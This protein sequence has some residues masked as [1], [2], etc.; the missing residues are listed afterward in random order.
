MMTR[1]IGAPGGSDEWVGARRAAAPVAVALALLTAACT[2]QA[3]RPVAKSMPATT[4]P[5]SEAPG[6]SS[7]VRPP[8]ATGAKRAKP[9]VDSCR[10]ARNIATAFP[11][12]GDLIIG[13]LSYGGLRLGQTRAA[14][15]STL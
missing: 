2:G 15:R 5:A 6:S 8:E 14:L 4:S 10:Q 3:D 12:P 13:P 1:S 9:L 7:S 11:N